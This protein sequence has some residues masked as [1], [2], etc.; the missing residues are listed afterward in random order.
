MRSA[1]MKCFGWSLL[2]VT[3]LALANPNAASEAPARLSIS[4]DLSL[5]AQGHVLELT[6]RDTQLA[7]A[8]AELERQIRSWKF[9]S[10]KVE[11]VPVPTQTHLHLAFEARSDAESKYT[12]RLMSAETGP[13]Y[14]SRG[15]PSYPAVA[16]SLRRQGLVVLSVRFDERGAVQDVQAYGD[17]EVDAQLARAARKAVRSWIFSPE[18][19]GGHRR[20]S[21][22]IV[23]ICFSIAGLTPP[24]CRVT[25]PRTNRPVYGLLAVDPAATLESDVVDRAP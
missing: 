9:S 11:G 16:A 7:S 24:D 23:P 15:S 8:H 12:L 21:T 18:V 6:T 19:V 14:G 5:D 2:A 20:A 4:W 22:A 3:Q 1:R 13:D 10:G 25:D 17:Q